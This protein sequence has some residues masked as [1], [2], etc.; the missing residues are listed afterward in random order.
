MNLIA[1]NKKTKNYKN[2]N[3]ND[4]ILIASQ[5]LD[6]LRSQDQSHGAIHLRRLPVLENLQQMNFPS[7]PTIA[8]QIHKPR[9]QIAAQIVTPLRQSTRPDLHRYAHPLRPLPPRL[10]AA[11]FVLPQFRTAVEEARAVVVSEHVGAEI[12]VPDRHLGDQ[13]RVE[14]RRS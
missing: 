4:F 5:I 9:I 8:T 13:R 1:Q 3:N 14:R 10:S 12:G 11:D 2:K 6:R 7:K